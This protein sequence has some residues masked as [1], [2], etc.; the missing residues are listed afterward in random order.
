MYQQYDW[1]QYRQ[2]QHGAGAGPDRRAR[3]LLGNET[4]T[5]AAANTTEAFITPRHILEKLSPQQEPPDHVLSTH[6]VS[7][8]WKF[9]SAR[10]DSFQST[11]N[12]TLFSKQNCVVL[13]VWFYIFQKWHYCQNVSGIIWSHRLF[14][15]SD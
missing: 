11:R 9:T 4:T 1:N 15:N 10:I 6:V 14:I 7:A 3:S 12:C 2:E 5:V 8:Q 13:V